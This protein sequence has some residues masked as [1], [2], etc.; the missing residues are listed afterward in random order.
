MESECFFMV[1][2]DVISKGVVGGDEKGTQ[3][4]EV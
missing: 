2:A 4:L 1:R 3:F